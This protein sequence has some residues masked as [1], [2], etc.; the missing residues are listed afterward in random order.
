M[1]RWVPEGS[2]AGFFVRRHLAL[3]LVC[4]AD[5]SCLLMC[6]AGPGDLGGG[7]GARFRPKFPG[8]NRADNLQPDRLRAPRTGSCQRTAETRWSAAP[9][10]ARE[11]APSLAPSSISTQKSSPANQILRLGF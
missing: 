3:E 11:F 9:G 1:N 5:F 7:P 6:G 4:G 2:L 10:E 8:K